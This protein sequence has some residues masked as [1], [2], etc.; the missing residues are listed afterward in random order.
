MSEYVSMCEREPAW[1]VSLLKGQVF[2]T[3]LGGGRVGRLQ[4]RALIRGKCLQETRGEPQ[5]MGIDV[6]KLPVAY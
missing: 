4:V 1:E 5:L 3:K 2:G 6:G